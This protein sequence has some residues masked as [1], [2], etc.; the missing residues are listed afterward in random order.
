MK[1]ISTK[2]KLHHC[3]YKIASNSIDFVI[4][5]FAEI[6]FKLL[7]KSKDGKAAWLSQKGKDFVLQFC[8]SKEKQ[9]STKDKYN[10]HVAF[11]S[12]TPKQDVIRL[13]K[14]IL[15]NHVSVTEGSWSGKEFY[16]DCPDV[17]LD[18]VIEI[19]HSSIAE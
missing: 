12:K 16:L 18:F 10:S 17:F 19:M 13:K 6:D 15:H 7:E 11:I 14:W 3:S 4:A 5:L 2:I 9:L 1:N 8:E